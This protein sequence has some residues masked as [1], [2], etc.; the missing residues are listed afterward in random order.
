MSRS[1]F[2]NIQI[3]INKIPSNKQPN[4]SSEDDQWNSRKRLGYYGELSSTSRA[5]HKKNKKKTWTSLLNDLEKKT[6]CY[7]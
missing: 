1:I 3:D 4:I 5:K 7:L 6:I 2:E